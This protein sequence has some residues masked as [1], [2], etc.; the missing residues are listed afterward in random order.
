MTIRLGVLAAIVAFVTGAASRAWAEPMMADDFRHDLV[1]VPLCGTPDVGP[2]AGKML[3]TV[4]LPDGTAVV[5]GQ[6]ML[7]RGTWEM[8]GGRIC[9]R[10]ADDP[11]E[12]RR[13]I[14]YE[15]IG[16]DRYRNSDGVELCIG[17]CP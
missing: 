8:E 3:C 14:E 17:P 15:K 4:H 2:F 6:G 11:L 7:V 16:Q 1:G 5:A 12:R 9:R 13:C 10:N